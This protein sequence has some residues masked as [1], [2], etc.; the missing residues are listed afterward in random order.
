[1]NWRT[2][3]QRLTRLRTPLR[4]QPSLSPAGAPAAAP[5]TTGKQ[6]R[7]YSDKMLRSARDYDDKACRE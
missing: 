4:G 5:D 6:R 2:V 3:W 7:G 1:M